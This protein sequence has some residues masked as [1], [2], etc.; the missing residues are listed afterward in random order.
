MVSAGRR[1]QGSAV[2][3]HF[4][5]FHHIIFSIFQ[6][7]YRGPT[8]T[9]GIQRHCVVHL[10]FIG[11]LRCSVGGSDLLGPILSSSIG[12]SSP[13]IGGLSVHP[14]SHRSADTVAS[15]NTMPLRCALEVMQLICSNLP[16]CVRSIMPI[17]NPRY[18]EGFSLSVSTPAQ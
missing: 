14:L 17:A 5:Q 16:I 11:G 1:Y 9:N 15:A 10:H 12:G 13:P 2:M 6:F 8:D 3:F 18:W 7:L 4:Y